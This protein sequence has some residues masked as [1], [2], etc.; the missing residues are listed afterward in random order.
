MYKNKYVL[1]L[2]FF[3]KYNLYKN[4]H[5]FYWKKYHFFIQNK[6]KVQKPK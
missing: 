3:E 6:K 1:F 5:D 4:Q 2:I